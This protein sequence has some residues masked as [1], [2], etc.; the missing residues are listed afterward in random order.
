[1]NGSEGATLGGHDEQPLEGLTSTEPVLLQV[2]GGHDH[3]D[4]ARGPRD[5]NFGAVATVLVEVAL[6]Q[7]VDLGDRTP[8]IR[9]RGDPVPAAAFRGWRPRLDLALN[10][11][12]VEHR[13]LCR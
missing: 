7:V 5:R 1:M 10:V 4:D 12:I 13:P 9:R 8:R 3:P 6:R 2:A 11:E